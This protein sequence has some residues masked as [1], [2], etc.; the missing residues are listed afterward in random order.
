MPSYQSYQI[1]LPVYSG[2]LDLLLHLIENNELDITSISLLVVTDQYLTH[3]EN[4][5]ESK[6]EHLLDFLVMAAR[7]LLIKS[8]ALLPQP[9]ASLMLED[10][11]DPAEMLARQLRDYKRYKEA[12]S[13]LNDRR[14]RGLRTYLRIAPTPQI[15]SKIDLTGIT[16]ELLFSAIKE[17]FDRTRVRE[18]SLSLATRERQL[19]IDGQ[20]EKL[21]QRMTLTGQTSFSQLLSE[22][23]SLQEISVTLLAVLE[24]IKRQEI[25][26]RQQV[27]FGPIEI[28]P[29]QVSSPGQATATSR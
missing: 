6:I 12:G 1:D 7:L 22:N 10:P 23:V 16:T 14:D 13:W 4:L 19:T 18:N 5:K 28:L 2:P 17:A 29:V 27:I 9:E 15:E 25:L 11:E 8:R 20:I 26:V 3:V 21:Q 24:L